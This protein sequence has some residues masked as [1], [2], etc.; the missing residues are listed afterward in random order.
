MKDSFSGLRVNLMIT[1][2]ICLQKTQKYSFYLENYRRQSSQQLFKRK[3]NSK[4]SLKPIFH[5]T[6][7]R[8]G[9]IADNVLFCS[10]SAGILAKKGLARTLKRIFRSICSKR[11]VFL[12][13]QPTTTEEKTTRN[14]FLRRGKT[15]EAVTW[16]V[17]ELRKPFE[18]I[19]WV[20][21]MGAWITVDTQLNLSEVKVHFT[22]L[23]FC[24]KYKTIRYSE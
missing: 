22:M 24:N 2:K 3:G 16:L 18:P 15:R 4:I 8:E 9:Q 6:M 10:S 11:K 13:Q 19:T 12:C 23:S 14:T 7:E 21:G 20:R 5:Y 1:S 17:R